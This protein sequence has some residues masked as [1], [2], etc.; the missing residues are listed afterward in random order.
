MSSS[1]KFCLLL[2]LLAV[3]YGASGSVPVREVEK[4]YD[5]TGRT[6]ADLRRA[7]RRLGPS[8]KDGTRFDGYTS[9]YVKWN[10]KYEDVGACRLTRLDVSGEVT[11]TLP[12]WADEDLASPALKLAWAKYLSALSVHE[13]GH[14]DIGVRAAA[15][16]KENIDRLLP[17]ATCRELEQAVESKAQSILDQFRLEEAEY[18]KTTGHGLT[19]GARF[20]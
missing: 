15:A 10:Y 19:Q 6:A 1:W 2:S 13:A 14:K 4:R 9:W 20:P 11:T 18:D 5:I 12:R 8:G 17:Q 7:M 16:V 3:L